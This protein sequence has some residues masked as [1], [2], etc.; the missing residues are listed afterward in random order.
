MRA[1]YIILFILTIHIAL[2]FTPTG[3]DGGGYLTYSQNILKGKLPYIDFIEHKPPGLS[4]LLGAFLLIKDSIYTIKI[5]LLLFNIAT[6]AVIFTIGSKLGN[7]DTGLIAGIIYLS[8]L[9]VYNGYTILVEPYMTF[10]MAMAALCFI[11]YHKTGKSSYLLMC[12]FLVGIS[13][14]FKQPAGRDIIVLRFKT[15]K[16][17]PQK[18]HIINSKFHSTDSGS[19]RVLLYERRIAGHDVQYNNSECW[20]L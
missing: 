19:G 7:R 1:L 12:G 14:L 10:F 13:V 17:E 5:S 16:N 9:I 15:H 20:I 18:H 8:G 6:A 2:L 4:Y 3:V 11:H